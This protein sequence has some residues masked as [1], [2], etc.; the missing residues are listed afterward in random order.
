MVGGNR[1]CL[2]ADLLECETEDGNFVLRTCG[3]ECGI[4]TTSRPRW[5]RCAGIAH[6]PPA[7][8]VCTTEKLGFPRSKG[9]FSGDN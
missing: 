3:V 5:L 6:E 1:N 8:C 4:T 2:N 9:R 7:L